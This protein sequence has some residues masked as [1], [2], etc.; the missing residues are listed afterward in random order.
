MRPS[1][2]LILCT[3]ARTVIATTGRRQ[4][5]TVVKRDV[6]R[7]I[8]LPEY[9]VIQFVMLLSEESVVS[10]VTVTRVALDVLLVV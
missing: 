4:A 6:T 5:T 3:L 10:V 8:Q 9:C 7:K 1:I 2:K